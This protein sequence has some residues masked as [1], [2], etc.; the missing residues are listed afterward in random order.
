MV[1]KNDQNLPQMVVSLYNGF[2][3]HG[4]ESVKENTLYSINSLERIK[5]T[6]P[7]TNIDT[8]NDGLEMVTPAS[9]MVIFSIY[10][11]VSKN[12]GTPKWMAYNGK[13]Y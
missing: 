5:H 9:N 1:G 3:Y 7:K 8:P 11:G 6:P 10:V 4:I 12:R 2:L 13:P